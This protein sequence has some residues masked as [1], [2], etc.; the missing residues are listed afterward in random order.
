[1]FPSVRTHPCCLPG[2]AQVSICRS[3][4]RL[5]LGRQRRCKNI[6]PFKPKLM[7]DYAITPTTFQIYQVIPST[8]FIDT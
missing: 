7:Y 3:L 6:E 4:K 5:V 2:G 8:H 1:M